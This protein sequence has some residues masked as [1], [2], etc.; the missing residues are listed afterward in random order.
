MTLKRLTHGDVIG[1]PD[2]AIAFSNSE[3]TKAACPLR[4][5]FG[6]GN[7]LKKPPS[8][9]ACMASAARASSSVLMIALTRA[10]RMVSVTLARRESCMS[11]SLVPRQDADNPTSA[12][13]LGFPPDFRPR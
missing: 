12:G 1:L 4:W 5:W 9:A 2:R 11:S 13:R 6:Y 8:T 3:R 10:C 7:R